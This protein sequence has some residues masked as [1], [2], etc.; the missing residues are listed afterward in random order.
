MRGITIIFNN[1][2]IHTGDDLDLVQEV[3]EI[4]KP[5]IQSYTVEVPG[6]NGLLNL[7]KALTGEVTYFN[8]K[9][10]FR[11]FCT[12]TRER[13]LEVDAILS[14]FHGETVKII[15][16]D[17]PEYY[18]EGEISVS[19]TPNVNYI[20]FDISV[21]ALPF[22]YKLEETSV[23]VNVNGETSVS[24]YYNGHSVTPRFTTDN[25]VS[26]TKDG[27]T[28]SWTNKTTRAV[29]YDMKIKKGNN[30]LTLTGNANVIIQYREE[31]I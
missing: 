28:V 7:T 15:D 4:G 10:T 2:K 9:L 25:A 22:R 13:M 23:A 29:V 6:R 27:L 26:V 19:V 11:Y 8:R 5:T 17:T 1:E 12:G 14:A 31:V 20:T 24:I 3:K 30:L 16:D 18:Y 21:N